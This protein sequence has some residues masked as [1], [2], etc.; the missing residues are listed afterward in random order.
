MEY[1][2]KVWDWKRENGIDF[3]NQNDEEKNQSLAHVATF[4]YEV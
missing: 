2:S 3:G 4:G 1:L